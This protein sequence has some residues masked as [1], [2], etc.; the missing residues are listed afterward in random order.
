[1]IRILFI[2][3]IS[4]LL[5]CCNGLSNTVKHDGLY[6]IKQNNKCGYI[7]NSGKIVINPQFDE[8]VEFS[9]GLAAVRLGNRVGFIDTKGKLV[10]NPQFGPVNVQ[11]YKFSDGLAVVNVGLDAERDQLGRY[12]YIDRDG[13]S[14]VGPQFSDAKPFSDG[15][16]VVRN[17]QNRS[18]FLDRSFWTTAFPEGFYVEESFH[19]G[20]AKVRSRNSTNEYGFVDTKGKIVFR[21]NY[22]NVDN[23]SEGLVAVRIGNQNES[24]CGYLDKTGNQT[25]APQFDICGVFSEGMAAVL[26]NQKLGFIDKSG[27][28]VISPQFDLSISSTNDGFSEGVASVQI[29]QKHGYVDKSG[30]FVVNPQFNMAF[31]FRGGIARVSND[32]IGENVGYIDK[33]GKYIWNPSK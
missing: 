7:N 19:D 2:C 25:I 29:A 10:I 17:D 5:L 6:P 22:A 15:F 30:R 14:V 1:M 27:K 21:G 23:F 13:K 11:D 3:L 31:P 16:A 20:L 12:G 8:C 4:L 28:I 32:G 9:E 24:K 18:Y 33:T 26:I